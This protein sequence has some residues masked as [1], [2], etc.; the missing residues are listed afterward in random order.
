[1][2]CNTIYKNLKKTFIS[3]SCRVACRKNAEKYKK[4]T[5]VIREK[6]A[7]ALEWTILLKTKNICLFC[8]VRVVLY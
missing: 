3:F 8:V 4:N 7:L 2:A 6:I 1:V 5:K